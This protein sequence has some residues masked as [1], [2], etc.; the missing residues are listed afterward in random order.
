MSARWVRSLLVVLV[1]FSFGLSS[2]QAA[3]SKAKTKAKESPPP[4]AVEEESAGLPP[5]ELTLGFQTRDSETEG[6][7]DLLLPVWSPGGTG[8]LFLNPRTA[9]I[10]HDEEEGNLG[11]GYRQWLAKPNVILGANL[12][13]DYRDTGSFNYDQWGFGLELLSPWIDARANYYDP[14]DKRHLIASETET[15]VSQNVRTS[16][17]WRDPYAEDHYVLQDYV[18]TRTLTTTTTTKTFEQY[19]QALGGYDWE[20]GLRLPIKSDALEARVFG[21]YYD[22]DRD[23]GDDACGWK[24]RAEV[25]VR[26]TLF[27]DAGLYENEDLTGSD[28]FAGARWTTPLDLGKLA[29][30]R[31]PFGTA[32]ARLRG[33]HRSGSARLTEMVLRDPQIRREQS[34]F[35]ENKAL[36]QDSS[37]SSRNSASQTYV[38]LPDVQFVDGDAAAGGNGSAEHPFLTIQQGANAVY[39]SRNVYVYNA[40]GPYN[41]NV[42]L[43]PDTTLWGSGSL[44][45][46]YGGTAFGSGVYPIV[47]GLSLGPTITMADRTTVRGFSVRNTDTGGADQFVIIPGLP[48]YNIRRAGIYGDDATDLTI[49][50]NVL[51]ANETGI[52]VGRLGDLN[53]TV[54]DNLVNMN[55][56]NGMDV[57]ASGGGAGTFNAAISGN[58]FN[59]NGAAGAFLYAD[60]YDDS[61]ADIRNSQFIGNPAFGLEVFQLNSTLAMSLLSGLAA[62]DNGM[63]ILNQQVNNDYALANISG[64]AANNNGVFGILNIQ[65]SRYVSASVF[66]MPDGLDTSV[67]AVAGL[68]GFPLPPQVGQFLEPAGGVTACGNGAFGIQSIVTAEDGLALGALF[69]VVANDNG[70]GGVFALNQAIEGVGIGLAGSSQ[71]LADIVDFGA[72][73][74]GMFG[75]DLPIALAGGGHMEAN[76]NGGIGFQMQTIGSNAAINLVLG[77]DAIGN[78]GPG[79]FVGTYSENLAVAALARLETTDNLGGG[80]L[81]DVF[82]RNTAAVGI[83]ADVNASDNVGNGITASVDSPEGVAALLTLSTDALRPAAALLGET[84][85]GAP[86][87]LPGSAFGPVVASGN[88]GTGIDANVTGHDFALA[89]FLDTQADSNAGDGFNVRV[90]SADGLGIA[91]FISTDLVYDNLPG[92]LGSGP[93][94]HATLGDV[95]ASDNGGNGFVVDVGSDDEAVL[96]M[97]GVQGD[98]NQGDGIQATLTSTNGGAAAILVDSSTD[99]NAGRGTDLLLNGDDDVL[100][101]LIYAD[102]DGNGQQGVRVRADSANGDAYALLAGADTRWNGING[103]QA[104]I[105]VDLTAGNGDASAAL[106]DTYSENN[107]GRGANVTLNA[108]GNANLF[109]GDFAADDLDAL[110]GFSGDIGP[111]F[112]LI[113][114]GNDVFSNNDGGGLHAELTSAAGNAAVGINGATADYNGNMGFNLTLNALAGMDLVHIEYAYANS[115]GGNGLNLSLNGAGGLADVGLDHVGANGNGAN[116]IQITDNYNG[117]VGILGSYL[118][119]TSNDGNGVRL[120]LSGLG[121]VPHLDFGGGGDS[122]GQSSFYANGNRDFRYNNGGAGTVMAE[123]NFWGADLDPVA[124]GQTAG[125]IDANPWLATAP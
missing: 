56:A 20:I 86:V 19:E 72:D 62:H 2:A 30:G 53:L 87:T 16:S 119:A 4:V 10:D 89:A 95:S 21:G 3:K 81:F 64:T 124:N 85:L 68:L 70:V 61:L 80:L 58:V 107:Y 106:T 101:G 74:A 79:A 14:D 109:V 28:W 115:N 76:G 50:D 103:N 93:I 12:Y 9:I 120:A 123:N 77:L 40:S 55:D 8:L 100:A 94:A 42:V 66:G 23:F 18:T 112:D 113:P 26:S 1:L 121:G 52:L 99:N 65:N 43:L 46:G 37:T 102:A 11:I 60:G 7:G 54:R 13:Y 59:Q 83:L 97:A 73:V 15:T 82:G 78:A 34:K 49:V 39:G 69:D 17:G 33:E 57:W 44:I 25:R 90:G 114:R 63:G 108:G 125:S 71:D 47:D 51:M 88:L 91:A 105:V 96:V 104:G 36:Q 24:T 111:L 32:K 29:Q 6:L 22:F 110:Y 27:L 31:N 98:R 48:T 122:L 41:E 5:A 67:A 92:V 84:F 116:G 75:F 118:S 35:I 117:S 45:P 38:L